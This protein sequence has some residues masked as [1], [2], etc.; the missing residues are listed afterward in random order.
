MA[1]EGRG[2][3]V[4]ELWRGLSPRGA[5]LDWTAGR[6]P[7]PRALDKSLALATLWHT[8]SS[9]QSRLV[10]LGEE[11]VWGTGRPARGRLVAAR[12]S[13]C[14]L[15]C[16]FFSSQRWL[17]DRSEGCSSHRCPPPTARGFL[18]GDR[19]SGRGGTPHAGQAQ[20][21]T[22][23]CCCLLTHLG[24]QRAQNFVPCS[25]QFA[26]YCSSFCVSLKELYYLNH[27]VLV[28]GPAVPRNRIM[29]F[30]GIYLRFL[31]I[32]IIFSL[33]IDKTEFY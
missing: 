24:P 19:G 25:L 23:P 10:P 1:T 18:P 8:H 9:R 3:V 28:F 17:R 32:N 11:G 31:K 4:K 29:L 30:L 26:I 22:Q 7:P 14:D 12:A 5:G 33:S 16:V 21:T 6:L 2:F 20:L 13:T 27:W 15:C